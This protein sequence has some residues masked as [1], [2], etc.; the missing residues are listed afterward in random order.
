MLNPLEEEIV[1]DLFEF[2]E[3]NNEYNS[4]LKAIQKKEEQLSEINGK[5]EKKEK[6]IFQ[7]DEIITSIHSIPRA[8]TLQ[9]DID[10]KEEVKTWRNTLASELEPLKSKQ[11]TI[12]HSIG[13]LQQQLQN[14][15]EK[16]RVAKILLNMEKNRKIQKHQAQD[17]AEQKK[18]E[19]NDLKMKGKVCSICLV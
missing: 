19:N 5:I 10:K 9:E 14:L 1:F 16:Y 15:K 11:G 12:E 3:T 13:E 18:M 6:I 2:E 4:L 17:F 7:C 8:Q